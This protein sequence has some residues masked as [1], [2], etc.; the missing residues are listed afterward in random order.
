[1][2]WTCPKCKQEMLHMSGQ[3]LKWCLKRESHFWSK[4]NKAGPNGCWLYT[5]CLSFEGRGYVAIGMGVRRKQWQ[6]HRFAWSLLKGDI[7]E[8][9]CVLHTCDVRNCVNPDH[10]YLGTRMDNKRDQRARQRFNGSDLTDEQVSE[11]KALLPVW[12]R[13]MATELARKYGVSDGV[14]G[15]IKRGETFQHVQPSA[16][17]GKE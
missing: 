7:P 12:K 11:I 2:S 17:G 13:G 5:G 8:D 14:I 3:H 4:V 6:A 10:L 9:K 16:A 1:M 15:D